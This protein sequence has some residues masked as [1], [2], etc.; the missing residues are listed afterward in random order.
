M[1]GL[2]RWG[3]V[4]T[5]ATVAAAVVAGTLI[6]CGHPRA[7]A[8]VAVVVALLAVRVVAMAWSVARGALPWTRL[9]LPG[10]LALEAAAWSGGVPWP[11][12]LATIGALEAAVLGVAIHA[13]RQRTAG[14]WREIGL[15]RALSALLPPG[16][17]RL[18][19][20]EV[21][22]V[23]AAVRFLAG[24]WRR[25]PPVGFGYHR[26]SGLRLMLPV[27]PLLAAGD[28]LL[29]ELVVLPRAGL[30]LR[31]AVHALAA[32]GLVWLVGLY[33]T[34]RARPHRLV[35]DQ[36]ELHRG[37]LR[38]R[39]VAVADVVA[40]APLPDFGDDWKRRAYCRGAARLDLAGAPVLEL[41]LRDGGRVLIAVDDPAPLIAAL[42]ERGVA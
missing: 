41:R 15:A 21:V 39:T 32:Y 11:V 17:A 27:L 20:L 40:V 37:V 22:I 24:G 13:L 29:L 34:A 2:A 1:A 6:A 7:D 42:R 35:G 14:G 16:L 12:R 33:A 25:P 38:T 18:A 28:W 31:L 36:L 19:A 23:G 9:L 3:T 30:G 26:E 4:A 8:A 10:V 5:V